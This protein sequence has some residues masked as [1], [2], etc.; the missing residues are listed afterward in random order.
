MYLAA[1]RNA[2]QATIS[3]GHHPNATRVAK[4]PHGCQRL[5]ISGSD[6]VLVFV[7]DPSFKPFPDGSKIAKVQWNPKQSTEAPFFEV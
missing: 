3:R 4:P 5:R 1:H 2:A 7:Y 6:L